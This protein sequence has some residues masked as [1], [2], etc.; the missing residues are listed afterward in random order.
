MFIMKK[1]I[2]VFVFLSFVSCKI[3]NTD[4]FQTHLIAIDEAMTP[5]SLTFGTTVQITI[6]YT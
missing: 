1:I 4:D 5:S 3:D 6:K 2:L